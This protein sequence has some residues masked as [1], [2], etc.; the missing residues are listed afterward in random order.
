MAIP[1][2]ISVP[3]NPHILEAEE[4]TGNFTI[5]SNIKTI[6]YVDHITGNTFTPKYLKYVDENNNDYTVWAKPA[7]LYIQQSVGVTSMTVTKIGSE[8]SSW[9]GPEVLANNPGGSRIFN[10][11]YGDEIVAEITVDNYYKFTD[12]S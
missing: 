5:N 4:I 9:S 6:T 11:S 2:Y 12:S 1:S 8:L 3:I 10:V 7:Q